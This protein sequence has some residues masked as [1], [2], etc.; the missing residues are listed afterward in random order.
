MRVF[1]V[2][3]SAPFLRTLIAALVH[4]E[5]VDGFEARAEPERLAQATLYLPTRRAGRMARDIFLDVL[6][7]DAVL[8]PRIFTLG[9]IDE[10]EVAFAEPEPFSGSDALELPPKLNEL[11]RRLLL[12]Q[13]IGAWAK[14]ITPQDRTQVPLV[15]GGPASTL[16]LA[17]VLARLMDDMVTR[18]VDWRALDGL[19]RD[20]LDTYWQL[21]LRFLNVARDV[22][23][24][25]LSAYG[26]IEPAARRDSDRGRSRAA[27]PAPRRAGDRRRFHRFDADHREFSTPS[28]GCRKARWCCRGS[29]PI[30]TRRRG[31]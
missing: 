14:G 13:M 22:W 5:L 23:P 18:K 15:V 28:A 3:S 20:A 12:A 19:V 4:G 24:D 1:S 25:I 26:G 11:Q 8:L 31:N 30:S 17:D 6:D 2:P 27:D 10:D 9:G 29:T 21:T 7:T 16:A